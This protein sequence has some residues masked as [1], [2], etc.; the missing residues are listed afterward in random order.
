[1]LFV[2]LC[3]LV[4]VAVLVVHIVACLYSELGSVECEPCEAGQYIDTPG[5][6]QCEDCDVGTH[7]PESGA[8]NCTACPAGTFSK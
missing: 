5:A 4:S 1:V 6:T 3:L 2:L 8:S 7:S